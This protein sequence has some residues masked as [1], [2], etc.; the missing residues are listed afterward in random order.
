[1]RTVPQCHV[2]NTSDNTSD[3]EGKGRDRL[4]ECEKELSQNDIVMNCIY[5][6]SLNDIARPVFVNNY[7]AG[8]S[9]IPIISKKFIKLDE[10]NVPTENSI[11]NMQ[12]QDH[13]CKSGEASQDSLRIQRINRKDIGSVPTEN[14]QGQEHNRG[15]HSEFAEP[16]QN[17]LR[18][19]TAMEKNVE[20]L[21]MESLQ[22]QC[23]GHKR[24]FHSKFIEHLQH[25]LGTLNMG[26]S[27]VQ[28]ADCVDPQQVPL[29]GY[30][31]F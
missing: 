29:T 25:L 8:E 11:R 30:E 13:N 5:C 18:M 14:L 17:S 16:S 19:Q 7:Y 23:Q 3:P 10:C 26:K 4:P 24:P 6:I 21:S 31:N 27:R 15:F 22:G 20:L 2:H 1:M 28:A 12:P 9:L